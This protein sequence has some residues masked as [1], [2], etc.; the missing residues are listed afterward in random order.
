MSVSLAVVPVRL[1]I[2]HPLNEDIASKFGGVSP[3]FEMIMIYRKAQ[4]VKKVV[5]ERLP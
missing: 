1:R 5:L 2:S 3:N 4:T